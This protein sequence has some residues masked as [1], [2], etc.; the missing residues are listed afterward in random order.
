MKH[1][2]KIIHILFLLFLLLSCGL[3][4]NITSLTPPQFFRTDDG[5]KY[6][7]FIISVSNDETE[8]RGL[9]IYYKFYSDDT[10]LELN[11]E[12]KDELVAADFK[13]LSSSTDS[14][15]NYDKP[16]IPIFYYEGGTEYDYRGKES[17]ITVDF[18]VFYYNRLDPIIKAEPQEAFALEFTDFIVRR[19][20]TY[21]SGSYTGDCKP[22]N[23]MSVEDSDLDHI[24]VTLNDGYDLNIVLYVLCFGRYDIST[25]IYSKA[26]CLQ[27]LTIKYTEQI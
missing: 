3:E 21:T 19:E 9:E 26:V 4:E 12:T 20:S 27:Y 8:L 2:L 25:P 10:N 5:D 6:F 18:S 24:S 7:Q 11:L 22:F 23:D 13:R 17:L 15:N 14:L 16:L 1:Y